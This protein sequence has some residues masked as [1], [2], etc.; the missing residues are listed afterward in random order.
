[1]AALRRISEATGVHIVCTTGY[2]KDAFSAPFVADKTVG[3][4]TRQFVREVTEGIDDT[5]IKAGVVKA[6][7][8]KDQVGE[9]AEKVLRA[10][11]R[12]QQATGAPVSTHTDAGTMGRDQVRILLE[13]G[14]D[15]EKVLIGHLDRKLEWDYLREI[16]ETG[17]TL[18]FDQISKEK[19]Y[20]DRKRIEFILRLVEAGYGDQIILSGDLARKSYWPA[21]NTGGGPGLTYILWRFVPWLREEGLGEQYIRQILV[22]TPARIFGLEP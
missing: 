20:P 14:A 2:H 12:T 5:G 7:T 16:A 22:E 3:D 17:V 13:E 10:A 4:L 19:Y 11:A 21:Y 6:G 8:M 1:P 15:P 18:G 9:N